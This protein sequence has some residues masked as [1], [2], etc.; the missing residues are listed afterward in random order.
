M[1]TDELIAILSE[2]LKPA[3]KGMVPRWLLP[4]LAAGLLISLAMMLALLGP[5]PDLHQAMRLNAFWMKF[6]YTLS[7]AILGFVL[8]ERQARAGANSRAVLF[9]LGAPVMALIVLASIQLSS[10]PSG[11]TA[12][13]VMGQTWMVCPW[14]I[15][16]LSLPMLALMLLALRQLAP[17]RLALAGA[18][19]GLVAG[20]GAATIYGFH[21]T[22]MAA[23][24]ILI[25]YTLGIAVAAGLGALLGERC[26][27]W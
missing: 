14:L 4:A 18:A 8:I 11:D 15:V 3:R 26:L 19:A 17:T 21:C 9:A 23:P 16:L 7:L 27:R 6:F 22:E 10:R 25:W 13:L 20:A 2:E 1:K 24:F 12:L 5:R